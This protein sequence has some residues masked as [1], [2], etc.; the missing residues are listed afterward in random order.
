MSK[1][2]E[3]RGRRSNSNSPPGGGGYT[4]EGMSGGG[5]YT[6]EGMSGGGYTVEGM[7]EE[8]QLAL[9]LSQSRQEAPP[10]CGVELREV[11]VDG[12][13]V[14]MHHAGHHNK[15]FSVKGISICVE[16]FQKMGHNIIVMM[17]RH[18]WGR[19]TQQEKEILDALESEKILFYTPARKTPTNSWTCYDDRFIVQYAAT[20]GAVVL[21]NDNYRDL[22]DEPKFKDTIENRI[23]P[24]T[25]VFDELM[26]PDDP[27]GR[28]GPKLDDF[29]RKKKF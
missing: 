23:L 8:E 20:R 5:G 1:S 11:V 6:V 7:S 29:L 13:N 10:S 15:P 25:W 21:S 9:A 2:P 24:Y 3:P 28:H 16:H 27:M 26:L 4:V 14:G 18:R 19:A 22:K 12:S 17:P